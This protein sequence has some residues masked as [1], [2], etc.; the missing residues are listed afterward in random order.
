MPVRHLLKQVEI[1]KSKRAQRDVRPAWVTEFINSV[2]DLFEPMTDVGRVGFDCRFLEDCWRVDLFLGSTEVVGGPNDGRAEHTNFRFDMKP[3][4]EKFTDIARFDWH[5]LAPDSGDPNAD[6]AAM[7][8][9]VTIE[10]H[11][12][13]NLLRLHVCSIPP[14]TAGPGFKLYP[15]G[16]CDIA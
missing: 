5:S 11:V 12:A 6:D 10:G 16:R 1:Y 14:N 3:L 4:L 7:G 9:H 15:D 2:A 13:S 8:S